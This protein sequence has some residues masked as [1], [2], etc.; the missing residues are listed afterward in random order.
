MSHT[1]IN[2]DL[3]ITA[4]SSKKKSVFHFRDISLN[5]AFENFDKLPGYQP[6]AAHVINK[7]GKHRQLWL[8][9]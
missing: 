1:V 5:K 4:V 2:K 9:Q 3:V 6:I 7:D 8:K